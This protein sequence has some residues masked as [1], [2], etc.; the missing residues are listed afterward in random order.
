MK[1]VHFTDW[2][3]GDKAASDQYMFLASD[4]MGRGFDL[5]R[6]QILKKYFNFDLH[7]YMF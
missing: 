6:G 3:I 5:Y 4:A 7:R 2:P 1:K